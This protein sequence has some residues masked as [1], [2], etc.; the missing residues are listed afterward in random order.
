RILEGTAVGQIDLD[1]AQAVT[2]AN[3]HF[4]DR[5]RGV[6]LVVLF[7]IVVASASLDAADAGQRPLQ[8]LLR[9]SVDGDVEAYPG[10]TVTTEAL[11]VART[12][13]G[14]LGAGV[15][16]G[17]QLQLQLGKLGVFIEAEDRLVGIGGQGGGRQGEAAEKKRGG[18]SHWS[19]SLSRSGLAT[20][21]VCQAPVRAASESERFGAAH[22][23]ISSVGGGRH[24]E[25]PRP[26]L[27]DEWRFDYCRQSWCLRLTV[28]PVK[29]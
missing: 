11:D 26:P 8:G 10:F 9:G 5:S 15:E 12:E 24:L 13:R 21:A 14:G 16:F 6:A 18:N 19:R 20:A 2:Q 4:N 3:I 28:R 25:G 27:M 29:A 17:G 7:R 22:S 23:S 1:A